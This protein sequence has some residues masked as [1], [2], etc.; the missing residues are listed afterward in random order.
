MEEVDDIF[1]YPAAGDEGIAVGA[2]MEGYYRFCERE[3]IKPKKEKLGPIYYGMEYNNEYIENIMKE[4][5]W[6][7]KAVYIDEIEEEVGEMV[8]SNFPSLS[9]N[10]V[11]VVKKMRR[12]KNQRS[13]L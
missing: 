3:G 6:N 2:A 4:T 9:S 8:A 7:E 12:F 11:F 10:P 5:G 13:S 1:F